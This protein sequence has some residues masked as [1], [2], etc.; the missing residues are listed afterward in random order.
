MSTKNKTKNLKLPQYQNDDLFD[1]KEV[2]EAYKTIDGAYGDIIA[3]DESV[4]NNEEERIS[5]YSSLKNDLLSLKTLLE[6][7]DNTVASNEE[8]RV[9]AEILRNTE[10]TKLNNQ[11]KETNT[12]VTNAEVLR[13][14]T[15]N[16]LKT[17]SENLI[18]TMESNISNYNASEETR[19][20]NEANRVSAEATR[21]TEFNKIKQDNSTLNT[22]LTKKVDNKIKEIQ[23]TTDTFKENINTSFNE[24]SNEQQNNFEALREEVLSDIEASYV[25]YDNEQ[26]HNL[27]SRLNSDFDKINQRVNDSSYLEYEGTSIKADNTY[28]G[29]TKEATV[30]GRTLQNLW[31]KNKVVVNKY[32]SIEGEYIKISPAGETLYVS[33]LIHLRDVLLKP[34]TI[35]TIITYIKENTITSMEGY[36]TEFRT[37]VGHSESAFKESTI[38]IRSGVTGVYVEKLTTKDTFD[39]RVNAGIRT[40]LNYA[41]GGNIVFKAMVLE[42]DYTNTPIEELPFVEG[43]Q[44]TG[45]TTKNLLDI[46]A[47]KDVN[48][49]DSETTVATYTKCFKLNLKPNTSYVLSKKNTTNLTYYINLMSSDGARTNLSINNRKEVA[50]TTLDDGVLYIT[51]QSVTQDKIDSVIAESGYLQLEEGATATA[52]EPYHTGY[53]VSGK[54]CGKNLIN[55]NKWSKSSE[56]T[57]ND[58]NDGS[59]ALTTT[60]PWSGIAFKDIILKSNTTYTLNC[61]SSSSNIGMYVRVKKSNGNYN[62]QA[63]WGGKI[64]AKFTTGNN[65]PIVK[66]SIETISA[67][68]NV[69]ISEIQLEENTVATSYEPYQESTYSYLLDE[70]LRQLPNGVADS[71]DLETGVLTRRVGK[72]VLDGSENWLVNTQIS[73]EGCLAFYFKPKNG[74]VCNKFAPIIS[75]KFKTL[76]YDVTQYSDWKEGCVY[77]GWNYG[78]NIIID[79]SKL[80]TQDIQGFKQWLQANPTTVYYELAE[81]T[82]EQLDQIQLKSFEGTTHIMSNNTLQATTSV[83]IPS[84]VQAVVTNLINENKS[85]IKDVDVLNVENEGLKETNEVQDELIDINMMATDEVYTMIEPLLASQPTTMNLRERGVSKLVD[86]YVAMVQRGLKTIEQIPSRYREEVK[87][88]LETLEK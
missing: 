68:E 23:S 56:A 60:S 46:E 28:Y 45:D 57:I 36:N 59:F 26:H 38:A 64:P 82:T 35:Y 32:N 87:S 27:E 76:I 40:Y 17:N 52:Y 11:L 80:T 25:G 39:E 18:S 47:F 55:H 41:Q 50:K 31:D 73:A 71:I 78:I 63:D 69:I 62:A 15:F 88:I 10:S 53:K 7:T 37:V 43:I 48:N 5:N 22:S 6:N 1:M 2:N 3:L 74:I 21:V 8:E 4:K 72:V 77:H 33:A 51:I 67:L 13:S 42:G 49:H 81:P 70:P 12:S 20:T 83:K 34:S 9:N 14:E 58:N 61:K 85:L 79:T 75:D 29:L 16:T 54:S 44:G 65:A 86:M 24:L 66:V 19:K 84:N 30:K